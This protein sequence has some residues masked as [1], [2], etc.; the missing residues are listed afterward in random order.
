MLIQVA[1]LQAKINALYRSSFSEVE[2]EVPAQKTGSAASEPQAIS[3]EQFPDL[4]E[5]T[6]G[7]LGRQRPHAMKASLLLPQF[8]L[9]SLWRSEGPVFGI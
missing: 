7:L 3:R 8:S 1:E 9:H 6:F 2:V 5:A 4:S